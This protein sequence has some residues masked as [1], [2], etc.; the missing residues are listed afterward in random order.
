[1]VYRD[2]NGFAAVEVD[3]DGIDFV[4][5]NACLNVEETK[6]CL[7]IPVKSIVSINGKKV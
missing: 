5:G 1:L 6:K 2:G 3:D 4:D 7:V